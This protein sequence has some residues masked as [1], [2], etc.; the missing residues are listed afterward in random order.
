M[1]RA[2]KYIHGTCLGSGQP[3]LLL[4]LEPVE[5]NGIDGMGYELKD[6]DKVRGGLLYS[7]TEEEET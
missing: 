7:P 5:R 4:A 6:K 1:L 3:S 2:R